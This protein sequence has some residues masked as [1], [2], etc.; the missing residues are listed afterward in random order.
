LKH[1]NGGEN[2]EPIDAVAKWVRQRQLVEAEIIDRRWRSQIGRLN[3]FHY[4]SD[5]ETGVCFKFAEL[6]RRASRIRGTPAP[7]V[8]AI[9]Y[10]PTDHVAGGV[11]SAPPVTNGE[12]MALEAL[13]AARKAVTRMASLA[14]YEAL[15]AVAV[16]DEPPGRPGPTLAPAQRR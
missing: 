6:S 3:R 11:T 5:I 14:A 10:E 12:K 9:S 15:H 7:T 16:C 2:G 8:R 1:A 4:L 13:E